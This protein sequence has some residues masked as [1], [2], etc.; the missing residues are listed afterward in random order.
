MI[1]TTRVGCRTN[2]R[3]PSGVPR[4]QSYSDRNSELPLGL[5]L[6]IVYLIYL[7][8][9]RTPACV[10]GVHTAFGGRLYCFLP[11]TSLENSGLVIPLRPVRVHGWTSLVTSI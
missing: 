11:P 10:A 7:I 5:E 6:E 3:I 1:G 9:M 2:V 8:V 4:M